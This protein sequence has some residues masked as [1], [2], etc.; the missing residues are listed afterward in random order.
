MPVVMRG[1]AAPLSL[2]TDDGWT[3]AAGGFVRPMRRSPTL[4]SNR[5]A[6]LR[7]AL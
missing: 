6:A 4:A 1:R 3:A 7:F 2:T 5:C